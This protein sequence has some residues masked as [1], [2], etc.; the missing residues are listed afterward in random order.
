[1][2]GDDESALKV[3]DETVIQHLKELDERELRYW[4]PLSWRRLVGKL[5]VESIVAT[6]RKIGSRRLYVPIKPDRQSA[7]GRL[8][9]HDSLIALC[10]VYGGTNVKFSS[11]KQ[12]K[13]RV[14]HTQVVKARAAGKTN[15]EIALALDIAERSVTRIIRQSRRANR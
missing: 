7:L 5:P 10:S 6:A 14:M 4:V 9:G 2:S 3:T 8:I 11:L 15:N 13:S 12:T 1:M